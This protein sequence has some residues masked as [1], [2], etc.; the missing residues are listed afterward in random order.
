MTGM[1]QT[2]TTLPDA[3]MSAIAI[4]LSDISHSA[5]GPIAA[6][7]AGPQPTFR[8]PFEHGG[9]PQKLWPMSL[10]FLRRRHFFVRETIADLQRKTGPKWRAW[11][12][13]ILTLFQWLREK[14]LKFL[15][16]SC[17]E[18]PW[19]PPLCPGF[20]HQSTGGIKRQLFPLSDFELAVWRR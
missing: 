12:T 5:S 9:P 13:W 4:R 19:I 7:A 6:I 1:G 8:D 11:E 2:R 16:F 15:L 10:K 18:R 17:R 20:G 14:T 3:W